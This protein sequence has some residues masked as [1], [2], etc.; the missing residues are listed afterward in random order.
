M[1]KTNVPVVYFIDNE[2]IELQTEWIDKDKAIDFIKSNEKNLRYSYNKCAEI[3]FYKKYENILDNVYLFSIENYI[4]KYNIL[5][6]DVILNK[7]IELRVSFNKIDYIY[8]GNYINYF[9]ENL[10]LKELKHV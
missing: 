8:G 10:Y 2:N 1:E 4:K 3:L 6:N 7:I 5:H 9:I